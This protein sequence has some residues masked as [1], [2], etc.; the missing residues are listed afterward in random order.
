MAGKTIAS[1]G[2]IEGLT[3]LINQFYYS[4]N[5]I[6][7]VNSEGGLILYNTKLNKSPDTAEVVKVKGRYVFRMRD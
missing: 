7:K 5:W 3:R 1:S 2:N 6:I 4:V